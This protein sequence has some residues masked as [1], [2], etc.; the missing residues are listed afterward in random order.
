MDIS[1]HQRG[2]VAVLVWNDDENRVN[3]DSLGRLHEILDELDAIDGPLGVVLTGQGKFF[4]NGLDLERFG[5]NPSEFGATLTELHRTIGRLLVYPAYCVAALNGH[6]FAAGALLSCA[7]DYRVMRSDR[8]YWCMNEAVIGLALDEKLWSILANRLPRSSAILAATTAHRFSGP[9]AHEHGI[10]EAL[11][12]ERDLL[13]RAVGVAERYS[14]LNRKILGEHKRL[15]HGD[16][17][18]FLGYAT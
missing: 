2:D 13:D 3:L 15:I 18:R 1:V 11:A 10:V 7:F 12:E 4:S 14:T 17:A 5:T 9:D 6:T 16:E 8:G